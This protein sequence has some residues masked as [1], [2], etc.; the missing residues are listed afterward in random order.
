MTDRER[1]HE[2]HLCLDGAVDQLAAAHRLAV[3]TEAA[4]ASPHTGRIESL[5]SE[6]VALRNQVRDQLLNALGRPV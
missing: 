3:G 6:A 1:L 5:L 4:N 2:L